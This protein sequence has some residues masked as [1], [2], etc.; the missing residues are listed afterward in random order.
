MREHRLAGP[1]ETDACPLCAAPP[2]LWAFD[3]AS[4]IDTI[5]DLD[6]ALLSR[7]EQTL[8]CGIRSRVAVI[9]TPNA[10]FDPLVGG[11]PHTMGYPAQFFEPG[12]REVSRLVR[13]VGDTAECGTE[14]GHIVGRDPDVGGASKVAVFRLSE[15]DLASNRA[16]ARR[17]EELH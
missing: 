7:L 13:G 6:A 9:T 8:F 17:T 11:L 12:S 1:V 2:D 15:T 16:G 3:S 14:V 10:D 4:L 5:E